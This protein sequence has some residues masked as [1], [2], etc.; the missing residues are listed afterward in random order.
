MLK[1]I[2]TT[3]GRCTLKLKVPLIHQPNAISCGIAASQMVLRFHGHNHHFSWLAKE[4]HLTQDG[5]DHLEIGLFFL[6]RGF[7]VKINC[8]DWAFPP[9]LMQLP[10]EMAVAEILKWARRRIK[11]EYKSEK[12]IFRRLLSKFLAAG[13]QF[14]PRPVTIKDIRS[15]IRRSE[16]PILS[17]N[18]CLL[19]GTNDKKT[20]GH[21]VVP[22]GYYNNN[23]LINDPSS[24]PYGGR[25]IFDADFL[26]YACYR[27]D[28][29]AI[30]IKPCKE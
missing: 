22:Y 18:S 17:V 13:G 12:R 20:G 6:E 28:A 11:H 10:E 15:A 5:T 1:S 4:M 3:I 9:R 8:W 29:N 21:Y 27:S 7:W 23:I 24:K 14:V 26:T 25:K 16:P 30:F 19:Y 2:R